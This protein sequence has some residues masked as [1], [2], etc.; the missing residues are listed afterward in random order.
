MS[1][2][3]ATYQRLYELDKVSPLEPAD[4]LDLAT[5]AYLV[6]KESDCIAA[7]VRAHQAFLQQRDL[8]RAGGIAARIALL[9]LNGGDTAQAA[10]WMGRSARLLDDSGE[11]GSEHGHLLLAAARQS[12]MGGHVR[13]A[14]AKFAEA[15]AIG[16][17]FGDADLVSLA[18][19]GHGRTLIELGEID[20]GVALL[21]EAMVAVT[22]GELSTIVAGVVYC[23]VISACFDLFDIGRA[24]EWTEALSRW[25]DAQ[26]EVATYRGEC[27]VYRAEIISLQGVWPDALHEAQLACER[28]S[29]P[30]G[31]PALGAALYQLAELHR[32][33]GELEHAEAAYRRS[34]ESGRSPYPGLALLRL[35]QGRRD[36]AVASIGRMLQEVR[37][38]RMRAKVL[39]AAVEI[40]TACGDAGA[41]R[42]AADELDTI[43][44]TLATPFMRALAAKARGAVLLAEGDPTGALSACRTA[45]TLWRE[46]SV[47]YEI[48]RAQ[49]LIAEAC[50]ALNDS[51]SAN[52]EL[53]SACRLFQQLGAKL[54][55]ADLQP[56]RPASPSGTRLTSRE[57]EVLRLVA[58]GRT[59]RAIAGQLRL[60]E[61]TVARHL[62]NIFNKLDVSSRA[63]ATAY[64]FEHR[65]VGRST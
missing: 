13:D 16:E 50:R 1:G 11:S 61:K 32:L 59:N 19:Q 3:K 41:A 29:T 64:A 55:L 63:A 22:A 18:R 58:T 23:S 33:R 39:S 65:L 26:P 48:A 37:Q 42:G 62:A 21:D 2:W 30:A 10:G 15:A 54:E 52:L 31:Q 5:S 25:C 12:I 45:C 57:L 34:A 24:R 51:D 27:L 9:L 36:D 56:S 20:R 38:R 60:S 40:M 47:P 17:R 44:R 35:A 14:E 7:L 46:L 6:G 28:L 8:R 43:A 4:L 53:E 49:V